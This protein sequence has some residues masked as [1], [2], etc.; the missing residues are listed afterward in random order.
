MKTLYVCSECC[1]PD[2]LSRK[3]H[4]CRLCHKDI[5]DAEKEYKREQKIKTKKKELPNG[6]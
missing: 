4:I 3:R 5:S 1:H 6:H 2:T